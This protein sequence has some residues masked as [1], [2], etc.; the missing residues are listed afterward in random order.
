[1]PAVTTVAAAEVV[2]VLVVPLDDVVLVKVVVAF[3]ADV[4]LVVALGAAVV[5]DKKLVVL[6]VMP[7]VV[8][9]ALAAPVVVE[10]TLVVVL[11]TALVVV[12]VADEVVVV[13]APMNLAV[14]WNSISPASQPLG[15]AVLTTRL[16]KR[17]K[18]LSNRLR[19]LSLESNQMLVVGAPTLAMRYASSSE[20]GLSVPTKRPLVTSSP[21]SLLTK[22]AAE[23]SE[24]KVPICESSKP[25]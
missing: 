16:S 2:V 13:L 12:A 24:P 23:A 6:L 15:P 4:V 17:Q 22:V 19:V 5:D 21:A 9:V 7:E 18:T 20:L 25:R 10:R 3:A 1:M 14:N 11:L 8:V